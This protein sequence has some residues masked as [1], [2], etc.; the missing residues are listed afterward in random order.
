[1]MEDGKGALAVVCKAGRDGMSQAVPR[2]QSARL[3]ARHN[4]PS[5]AL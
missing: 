5:P 2:H 3:V 4:L 1:M